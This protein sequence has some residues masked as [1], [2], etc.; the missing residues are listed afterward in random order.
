M[1]SSAGRPRKRGPAGDPGTGARSPAR[2]A[3]AA[4]TSRPSSR[5]SSPEVIVAVGAVAARA[6]LGSQPV[7][8]PDDHGR[9]F[10]VDGREV[11]VLLHPANAS[12]HPGVWPTYRAS[13]LALF[14][15]LAARAGFPV[16][17]GGRGGHLAA[18]ALPRD[19][20]RSGEAP[21]RTL[22]VPRRQARA[23]G[24]D[25]GLPR[26]GARRGARATGPGRRA[27]G[28]R[29]LDVSGPMRA[30]PLLPL[31]ARGRPAHTPRGP[32]LPVG[33]PGGARGAA[34]AARG[35]GARR[36]PH[37]EIRRSGCRR[38]K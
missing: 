32:A 6:I 1:P 22:G 27:R 7:R 29:A 3:A 25:R 36:V 2:R 16:V 38:Q 17:G 18:G 34:H 4:R 33:D 8:L 12:R 35:R 11:I 28:P 31:P 13:L 21:R 10:R 24:V 20:T 5:R 9:R 30:S 37:G 26:S 15:E 14:A 23:R 19:A